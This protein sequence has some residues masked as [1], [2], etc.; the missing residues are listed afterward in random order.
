[1]FANGLYH[2]KASVIRA[3]NILVHGGYGVSIEADL[4]TVTDE[5]SGWRWHGLFD[6]G[7][8]TKE[9][10]QT[11]VTSSVYA[12]N[13]KIEVSSGGGIYT[14]GADFL[15]QGPGH[16]IKFAAQGPVLL[17]DVAGKNVE[18]TQ[19]FT[20]SGYNRTKVSSVDITP[21]ILYSEKDNVDIQ[22]N[23]AVIGQSTIISAPNGKVTVTAPTIEFSKRISLKWIHG[24]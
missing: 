13:G 1:M 16:A 7:Y 8:K 12:A 11:L 9:S 21:S 4:E 10:E 23:T 17:F 18:T 15:A 22:S 5:E 3:Q 20:L 24:V 2:D 19:S 14:C 6:S